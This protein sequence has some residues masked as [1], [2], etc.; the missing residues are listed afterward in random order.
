MTIILSICCYSCHVVKDIDIVGCYKT[1]TFG[2]NLYSYEMLVLHDNHTYSRFFSN[3][4]CCNEFIFNK[5]VRSGTWTHKSSKIFL[6]SF[7]QKDSNGWVIEGLDNDLQDSV[8][9]VVH[10]FYNSQIIQAIDSISI[11]P[12]NKKEFE[13]HINLVNGSGK[14]SRNSNK[15]LFSKNMRLTIDNLLYRPVDFVLKDSSCN[16]LDVYLVQDFNSYDINK[17]FVFKHG[18]LVRYSDRYKIFRKY[19]FTFHRIKNWK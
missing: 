2:L 12:T 13:V 9:I 16:L 17:Q 5:Y 11:C 15:I 6:T 1:T 14:I 8:K 3:D 18:D 10:N 4:T 19:V 7:V